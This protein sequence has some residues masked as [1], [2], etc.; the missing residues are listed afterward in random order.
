MKKTRVCDLFGVDYALVQGGMLWLADAGLAAA[1]SNAGAMG[2]IS[3]YAGMKQGGDP[4]ENLRSQIARARELT[5]KPFGVNIPL[6]LPLSG[7]LVDTLFREKVGVV[8]TA[9][10]SPALFTELLHSG[11]AKVLHVT[12]SVRQAQFAESCNVDAVIAEG[13][14]AGARSGFDELAAFSLIPQI[15]DA[16]SIPVIAAGGVVDGRGIAAAI[17][18]G[19]EGVQMGTR[20]VAVNESIAHPKYKEALIAA[21]DTDTV[22]T[23]R[24]LVPTRS[25]KSGFTMKMWELERSGASAERLREVMGRGRARKAQIDGDLTEGDAYAGSSVGLIKDIVPVGALVRRLIREYEE[26]VERMAHFSRP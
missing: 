24:Q 2:I 14:E 26:T 18:L 3:P 19:A 23:A 22:M 11:G 13:V 5:D 21:L 20:F 16:V 9:A 10:G 12:S 4:V 7:I 8:V 15:A 1:V 25:L 17:A 6:D